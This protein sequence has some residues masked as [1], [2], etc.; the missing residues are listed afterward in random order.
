MMYIKVH[1]LL[2]SASNRAAIP[3]R[4]RYM[5]FFSATSDSTAD[6]TY[7]ICM[8][9]FLFVQ[10]VLLPSAAFTTPF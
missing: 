8:F 6:F 9:Q 4:C 2:L 5:Y 1:V 3:L 10:C 7:C